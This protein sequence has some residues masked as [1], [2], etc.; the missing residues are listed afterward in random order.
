[1]ESIRDITLSSVDIVLENIDVL[2]GPTAQSLTA[3]A[4]RLYVFCNRVVGTVAMDPIEQDSIEDAIQSRIGSG[5]KFNTKGRGKRGRA[6]E[7]T[8]RT[9]QNFI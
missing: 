3:E 2:Q 4:I 5:V 9:I 8:T 1:V 6:A 7:S